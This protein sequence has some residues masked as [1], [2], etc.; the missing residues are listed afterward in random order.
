M[1][2]GLNII[3]GHIVENQN[4]V[5]MARIIAHTTGLALTTSDT[6]GAFNL[7]IFDV[8]SQTP[9]TDV[10]S[11]ANPTGAD[12]TDTL[13][14][15]DV[16]WTV[17]STGPNFDFEIATSALTPTFEGGHTYRVE[18]TTSITAGGDAYTVW[19]LACDGVLTV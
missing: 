1:S 19:E 14:N 16:R 15:A 8:S 17:D 13:P 7:S 12:I 2:S 9:A 18:L 11:G 3:K 5:I 4:V 6:T 10:Y